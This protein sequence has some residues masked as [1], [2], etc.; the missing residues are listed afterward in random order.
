MKEDLNRSALKIIRLLLIAEAT[1][2]VVAA[3][4]FVG[5]WITNDTTKPVELL[6][7]YLL[8]VILVMALIPQSFGFLWIV[9]YRLHGGK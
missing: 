4:W 6:Q 3:I 2:L 8:P 9:N 5:K 7:H 1:V